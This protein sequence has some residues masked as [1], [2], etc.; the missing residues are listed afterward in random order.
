LAFSLA[1]VTVPPTIRSIVYLPTAQHDYDNPWLPNRPGVARIEAA[2]RSL[3]LHP[4]AIFV[5]GGGYANHCGVTYADRMVLYIAEHHPEMLVRLLLVCGTHNRTIDDIF[6]SMLLLGGLMEER[7]VRF[8]P[9]E[10]ELYFCSERPHYDRSRRTC[11]AM[12]LITL[13]ED[14]YDSTI[15][16]DLRDQAMAAEIVPGKILGLGPEALEWYRNAR[17]NA[18][19]QAAYCLHWAEMHPEEDKLFSLRALEVLQAVREAGVYIA[20]PALPAIPRP[21]VPLFPM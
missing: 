2:R 5:I 11:E 13:H 16:Y 20:S 14:S 9:A 10:C 19:T 1:P 8:I 17:Y 15:P 7:G 6:Q 4:D 12:G 3:T 21:P 18:S